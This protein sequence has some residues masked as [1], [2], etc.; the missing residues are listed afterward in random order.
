MIRKVE[1]AWRIVKWYDLADGVT[2]SRV[3]AATESY[4]WGRMKARYQ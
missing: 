4:S 3:P 1:G 2:A